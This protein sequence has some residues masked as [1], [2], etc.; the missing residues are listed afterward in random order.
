MILVYPD[1]HGEILPVVV[2]TDRHCKVGSMTEGNISRYI[3]KIRFLCVY[4]LDI[5]KN[6][7][8]ETELFEFSQ[9][10]FSLPEAY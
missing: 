4:C 9:E 10:C 5:L 8:R 7:Q 2:N 1:L 6:Y 3:S